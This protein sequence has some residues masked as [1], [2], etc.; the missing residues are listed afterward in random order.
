MHPR[1]LDSYNRELA[2]LREMG[3]EFAQE[4]PKVAAR[5]GMEGLE[6]ADPYVERLMEGFAFVAARIQLKLDAEFPRFTQ[7]LLEMIYPHFLAPMPSF[8]VVAMKPN[9][10]EGA[11]VQG[12]RVPRGSS[13]RSVIPRGQQ[14]ACEFR[15]AHDVT[16]YPVELAQANYFSHAADL[17]VPQA[18]LAM[19]ARSGLRL[20]LAA[21]AGLSFGSIDCDALCFHINAADD[22]AVPLLE[23]LFSQ[24]AGVMLVQDGKLLGT[25]DRS[26]LREVG[27][28]EDEAL[29]PYGKRSFQ[30]YR[31]LQEYFA[32]PQRF[33][34]FE[35]RGMAPLLR[36]ASSTE[37]ELVPLFARHEPRLDGALEAAH[38]CLYATPVANLLERR[39]DRVPVGDGEFEHHLVIDR[40]RP[41]DY[42]VFSIS[43]LRGFGSGD[44]AEVE[45][46]PFHASLDRSGTRQDAFYTARREPRLSSS[47]QQ[48]AGGR[49]SYAGSEIFLSLVDAREAPYPDSIRQLG[50]DVWATN[51]DLPL[52]LPVAAQNPLSLETSAPVA[53]IAMVRGPTRPRSAVPEGDV[54]W[55]LIRH[56]SLNYLSLVDEGGADSVHGAAALRGLLELY[57]D[58]ANPSMRR[59]IDAL[60]AV[61][62][63]PVIRRLPLPGP[64]AFGRGLAID[65][66]IDESRLAGSGGFLLGAVLDRFLA[67]HAAINTFTQTRLVSDSRA[68]V[69]QWPPR[70]G[71]K[72][73]A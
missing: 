41:L 45:F 18:R 5:L 28:D 13:L 55:R 1:L 52:L 29:L 16:L 30:G 73:L 54:A 15:T 64:I 69:H 32:F 12:V 6:V 3:A 63:Q 36:K 51:R 24:C 21:Q 59:Q 47:R 43:R 37:V 19:P 66:R 53:R 33:L 22:L 42:E 50:A 25:L 44:A 2:H 70:I 71:R 60:Q 49:S 62:S 27:F 11:L 23:L 10:S 20:K 67:Q 4:F 61:T 58:P 31:L 38:F 57:A 48:Q 40:T 9:F 56:L 35:V 65:I 46:Q 8:G 26:C 39:A 17:P 7:H 68:E 72:T 34:F 14:T